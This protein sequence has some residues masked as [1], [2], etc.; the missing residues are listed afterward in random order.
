[1]RGP[2]RTIVLLAIF[3]GLPILE[4][5][6]IIQV[7]QA[8]GAVPT[9]LLLIAEAALGVWLIKREGR[10]TWRALNES[11]ATGTLPGRE[12]ADAA[13]MLVGGCPAHDPGVR[14]RPLRPLLRAAVHPAD[15]PPAAR[16]RGGSQRVMRY[17][18]RSL[19]DAD[20]RRSPPDLPRPPPTTVEPSSSAGR[21]GWTRWAEAGREEA[22]DRAGVADR[23]ADPA[24][25]LRHD[26]GA[27]AQR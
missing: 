2:L 19:L 22:P 6:V 10:R 5:Y 26:D 4:I 11:L 18:A 3:I 27:T 12:L 24:P 13:I 1:M 25:D 7:G 14:H 21:A 16:R 8:I 20:P 17:G 9:I 15:R 23:G